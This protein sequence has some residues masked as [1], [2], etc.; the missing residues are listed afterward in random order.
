M[1]GLFGRRVENRTNLASEMRRGLQ[2]QRGLADARLSPEQDERPGN[3]AAA[4]HAIEFIDAS[5]EPHAVRHLNFCV[6]LRG[7]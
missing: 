3:D 6:Q 1:L 4:K 5:R 2:Q 7:G